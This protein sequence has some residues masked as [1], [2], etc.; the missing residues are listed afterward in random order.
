VA[1]KL[2]GSPKETTLN[3]QPAMVF[4][5]AGQVVA[6]LVLDI[7][8]GKIVGVRVVSNPEK[9]GRLTAELVPI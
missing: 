2:E 9:L 1:K 5:H 6:A 3:G 4:I 8:D 7:L